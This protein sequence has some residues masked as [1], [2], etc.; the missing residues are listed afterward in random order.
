MFENE[1]NHV[2]NISLLDFE[3]QQTRHKPLEAQCPVRSIHQSSTSLSNLKKC[4]VPCLNVEDRSHRHI[5]KLMTT[6]EQ[7]K[8]ELK[9]CSCQARI[10]GIFRVYAKIIIQIYSQSRLLK[11]SLYLS[12]PTELGKLFE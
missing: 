2:N 1:Q 7:G 10:L 8:V 12:K 5:N 9:I 6:Y 3:N 11:Y 4:P